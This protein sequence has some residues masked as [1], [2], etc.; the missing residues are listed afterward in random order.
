MAYYMLTKIE[1]AE[2]DRT[3]ASRWSLFS[4]VSHVSGDDLIM[5]SYIQSVLLLEGAVERFTGEEACQIY[6]QAAIVYQEVRFQFFFA[7]YDDVQVFATLDVKIHCQ[8]A[9]QKSQPVSKETLNPR[10]AYLAPT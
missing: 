3:K 9:P 4:Y 6:L 7:I 8:A 1:F 10:R 2:Y 5:T